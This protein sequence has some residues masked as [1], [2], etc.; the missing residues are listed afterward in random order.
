MY[1]KKSLQA[2]LFMSEGKVQIEGAVIHMTLTHCFNLNPLLHG[3]T[4]AERDD[5]PVL[6]FYIY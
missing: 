4:A 6:I 2:L 1:R 3:L 5:Q